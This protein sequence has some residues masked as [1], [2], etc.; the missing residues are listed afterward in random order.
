M[1][2]HASE[3]SKKILN[4]TIKIQKEKKRKNNQNREKIKK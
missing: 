3:K 4:T 2:T 1:E